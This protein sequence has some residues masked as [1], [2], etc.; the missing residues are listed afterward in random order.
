MVPFNPEPTNI[1]KTNA[2]HGNGKRRP[3]AP[4]GLRTWKPLVYQS[5]T[6]SPRFSISSAKDCSQR[7]KLG[8]FS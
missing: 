2:G 3:R 5:L 1:V 8:C 4:F 6:S 7:W